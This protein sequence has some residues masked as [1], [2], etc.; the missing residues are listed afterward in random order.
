MRIGFF[1]GSFDPPHLGHLAVGHA[2]AEA[3]SLDR[4]L[5]AP[6]GRQPLKTNGAS[7]TF[8]DRL[9]MVSLLCE[10]QPPSRRLHFEASSVDA[11]HADGSPNYTVDA[12]SKLRS[13]CSPEDSL[14]VL[15]GAD[16]FLDLR[17]WRA[18]DSLLQLAEWI[19]VSRPGVSLQ[20]LQSL[21]LTP[22]QLSQ[23]H[24]LEDVHEP[25]NATHIRELLR[26]GSDCS[27]LLPGS[28]L[29][30]IHAHHLYGT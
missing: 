24:L 6:T 14:Y 9:T 10:A 12:L 8:V 19:V 30:Y 29:N 27:G 22:G 7:A 23:V 15:V 3:F 28:I 13:D 5:F 1:G 25:A 16:A 20:Q 18:P 21:N 17:R 2:A 26:V 4:I 11:P